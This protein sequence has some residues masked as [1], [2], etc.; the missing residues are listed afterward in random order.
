M[1]FH[2]SSSEITVGNQN[3]EAAKEELVH[4]C[5][6]S[7]KQKKT[8]RKQHYSN[9]SWPMEFFYLG[10]LGRSITSILL[11][12]LTDPLCFETLKVQFSLIWELQLSLDSV[13]SLPSSN[14]PQTE[15]YREEAGMG[16][17]ITLHLAFLLLFDSFWCLCILQYWN[18]SRKER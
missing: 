15:T 4:L 7:I 2:S 14:L 12:V 10:I 8:S 6:W 5:T 11:S 13:F 3:W 1:E 17:L 18:N 9:Y 16:S